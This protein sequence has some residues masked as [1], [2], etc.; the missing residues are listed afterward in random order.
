MFHF[1]PLLGIYFLFYRIT[2]LESN[3]RVTLTQ[4]DYPSVIYCKLQP[5]TNFQRC[6]RC[7]LDQVSII[8]FSR[9]QITSVK[10]ADSLQ[11]RKHSLI[12]T[13]SLYCQLPPQ[14]DNLR[15]VKWKPFSLK[16][17]VLHNISHVEIVLNSPFS[18]NPR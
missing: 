6:L 15:F 4:T 17:R 16:P 14:Q 2:N 7:P 10:L 9:S 8:S 3:F 12:S 11:Y 1:F 13:I 5:A 18:I